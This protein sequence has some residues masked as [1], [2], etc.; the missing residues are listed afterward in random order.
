MYLHTCVCSIRVSVYVH[1]LYTSIILYLV[2]KH[3]I[4]IAKQK[5]PVTVKKGAAK[6]SRINAITKY[7]W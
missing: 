2:I 3:C 5:Q 1:W 4:N 7:D 6:Q